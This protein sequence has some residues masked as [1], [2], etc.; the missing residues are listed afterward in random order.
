MPSAL[1][2]FRLKPELENV[3][4]QLSEPGESLG[5][6]AQRLL[7]EY[8]GIHSQTVPSPPSTPVNNIV[9]N[10]DIQSTV[11]NCIQAR[12][13][14]LKTELLIEIQESYS[15]A[16]AQLSGMAEQLRE[17]MAERLGESERLRGEADTLRQENAALKAEIVE[18]E[19]NQNPPVAGDGDSRLAEIQAIARK[20]QGKVAG[21]TSQPRWQ[22]AA[23]LLAEIVSVLS[24]PDTP[25]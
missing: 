1:I 25:E 21:K 8:L 16:M 2:Q 15:T 6:T 9:D 5:L 14:S 7:C 12:L 10:P 17:E 13:D 23:S 22:N 18:T 4:I 24:Q 19:R 3:L 11:E 20:W